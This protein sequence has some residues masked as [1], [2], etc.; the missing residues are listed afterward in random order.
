[1]ERL[2]ALYTFCKFFY[3]NNI[4]II[5]IETLIKGIKLINSEVLYLLSLN[6]IQA[7]IIVINTIIGKEIKL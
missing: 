1:M 6:N 2:N 4:P 3:H 5:K 7:P